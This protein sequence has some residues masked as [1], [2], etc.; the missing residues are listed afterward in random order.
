[1]DAAQLQGIQDNAT[2]CTTTI[3][4]CLPTIEDLEDIYIYIYMI[5]SP[6]ESDVTNS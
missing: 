6:T 1:M 3:G 2:T 5:P 4:R